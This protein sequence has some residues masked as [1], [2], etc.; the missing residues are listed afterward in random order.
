MPWTTPT[1]QQLTDQL[2][3]DMQARLPGAEATPR[4]VL[5]TVGR[6]VAGA[7]SGLHAYLRWVSRQVLPDT[8]ETAWL[9]RHAGI[10]GL[11]RRPATASAGALALTGA[12]GA[13]VP[14]GTVWRSADGRRYVATASA[15]LAG[16]TGAIAVAA[17]TAGATGDLAAGAEVAV[18]TPIAGLESAAVVAAGGLGGGADLETDAALR[19]RVLR[20]IQQPPHGG[21]RHDYVAWAL[22]VPGVARAWCHPVEQGLGTVIV[23]V[24]AD[25]GLPDPALIAALQAHLDTARPVTAEVLALAPVALPLTVEIA[26]LTPDTAA[27][28]AAVEAEIADLVARVAAPGDGAGQGTL[29]V[30]HLREAISRAA[31]ETDHAL[32]S[33]TADVAPAVGEIL[34]Y[35]S[36]VWS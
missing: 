1:L 27:V 20:R 23:R 32:V 13:V 31:G 11:A 36:V 25:D 34:R 24:M 22:E 18:V 15:T 30:S 33:P 28:C 12:T 16:G 21:A 19:A 3:A 29:R 7:V 8:A 5:G 26:D 4:T 9:E 17:E 14:M 6:A 2:T 35:D 10:W